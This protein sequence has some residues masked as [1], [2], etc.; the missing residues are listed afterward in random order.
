MN[1]FLAKIVKMKHH[2]V[3]LLPVDMYRQQFSEL[4]ESITPLHLFTKRLLDPGLSIIAEIKRKSPSKGDLAAISKPAELAQTYN[5]AGASAV[6]I[7]TDSSYFSGSIEDLINVRSCLPK[8]KAALLRKDFIVD[9]IQVIESCLVGADAVLLIV[10]VL[11][12]K[13]KRYLELARQ[14]GMDALVEVHTEPELH[15]ALEAG[16]IIIGINNRNLKTF[17]VDVATSITLGEQIPADVVKVSESGIHSL[18]IVKRLTG[19]GFDA[20][21]VGEAFVKANDPATL[22]QQYKQV[23]S[24]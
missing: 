23:S 20:I 15:I 6:S 16:A 17:E 5:A 13:I 14:C 10:A 18:D 1:D 9:E 2:E 11:G 19:S 8:G 12:D 21:L 24:C 22:I 3:S 4:D 7:L